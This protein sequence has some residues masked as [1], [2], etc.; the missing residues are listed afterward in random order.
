LGQ[1]LIDK[2]EDNLL[3]L[4]AGN[5]PLWKSFWIYYMFG[6]FVVNIPLFMFMQFYNGSYIF[7]FS[8]YLIIHLSYYC[9]SC[10]GV[11]WSSQSYK[12]N[13]ILPFLAKLYIVLELSAALFK[14]KNILEII[15]Y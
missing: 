3:N 12:K 4:F 10:V 6:N 13:K 14:Y 5:L 11:W 8:L 7:S 2:L 1:T 9:I 15:Y